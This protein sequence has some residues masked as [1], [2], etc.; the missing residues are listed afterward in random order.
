MNF[1]DRRQFEHLD[2]GGSETVGSLTASKVL[3]GS[4]MLVANCGPA[5]AGP[6]RRTRACR[7]HGGH[8]LDV[9]LLRADVLR[10][11]QRENSNDSAAK[12][13]VVERWRR[14]RSMGSA[15]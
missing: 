6:C 13:V 2:D 15:L 12:N 3:P 1:L 9:C 10:Q 5:V 7:H 11:R 14:R 8:R 4:G